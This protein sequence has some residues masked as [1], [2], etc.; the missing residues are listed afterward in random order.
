MFRVSECGGESFYS[1]PIR[2]AAR[3]TVRSYLNAK[4]KLMESPEYASSREASRQLFDQL[5]ELF[6]SISRGK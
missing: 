4:N 1:F 2:A 3:L 6:R 5:R